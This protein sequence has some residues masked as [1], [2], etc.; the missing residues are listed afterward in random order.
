MADVWLQFLCG[1]CPAFPCAVLSDSH[2]QMLQKMWLQGAMISQNVGR[3][4]RQ[5]CREKKRVGKS[6]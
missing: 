1:H 2:L 3:D 6:K 4:K 5:I